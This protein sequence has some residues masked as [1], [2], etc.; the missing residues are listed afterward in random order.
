[1][2]NSK[3]LLAPLRIPFPDGRFAATVE[4][5]Q[6]V[7][8]EIGYPVV[9]K[10]YNANHGRG[11]AIHLTDDAQ[12]HALAKQADVFIENFRPGVA[13]RIGVGYAELSAVN[14]RLIYAS[15]TGFGQTGRAA[16]SRLTTF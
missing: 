10:P 3:E 14:P 15:V 16:T 11:V 9:V 8:S 2:V 6:A 12:V 13:D 1:M 7:A 4:E 5:A